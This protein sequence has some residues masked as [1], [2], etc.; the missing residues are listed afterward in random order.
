MRDASIKDV[1]HPF[2]GDL[3]DKI[4][5]R[6]EEFSAVDRGE[7]THRIDTLHRVGYGG[8]VANVALDPL[9]L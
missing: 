7:V 5:T 9:D 6:V 3:E 2:H 8:G 4:R 1:D